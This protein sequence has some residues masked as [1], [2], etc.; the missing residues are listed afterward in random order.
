MTS[1]TF[2]INLDGRRKSQY[3]SPNWFNFKLPHQLPTYRLLPKGK[4]GNMIR[5]LH[6]LLWL[7]C[8]SRGIGDC[9]MKTS[10]L[11][12]E[13]NCSEDSI[14]RY[15][16]WLEEK[17]FIARAVHRSFDHRT[18]KYYSIRFFRVFAAWCHTSFRFKK[19]SFKWWRN[20]CRPKITPESLK[21][22]PIE[23]RIVQPTMIRQANG[24]KVMKYPIHWDHKR[25]FSM[26]KFEMEMACSNPDTECVSP[27]AWDRYHELKSNQDR[28]SDMPLAAK[29]KELLGY[30]DSTYAIQ[31][32]FIYS[33][34]TRKEMKL[35]LKAKID[36]LN[37]R[38]NVFNRQAGLPEFHQK[39]LPFI[40]W[41]VLYDELKQKMRPMAIPIEDMWACGKIHNPDYKNHNIAHGVA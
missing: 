6:D 26:A 29:A 18:G 20:D 32:G 9:K 34:K 3:I 38:D 37:A 17:D 12:K 19:D 41:L 25:N 30:C 11:A 15:L 40:P 36:A 21:H 27:S 1:N 33:A 5:Q 10:V 31:R 22:I 35:K 16:D 13:L 7:R 8:M 23:Y 24:K 2:D 4:K 14:Y 28:S 39:K